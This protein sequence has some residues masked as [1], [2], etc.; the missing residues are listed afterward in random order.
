MDGTDAAVSLI[1]RAAN[2][3]DSSVWQAGR[4]ESMGKRR[5]VPDGGLMGSSS[6]MMTR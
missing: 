1:V 2:R 3:I 6:L 5:H 4:T